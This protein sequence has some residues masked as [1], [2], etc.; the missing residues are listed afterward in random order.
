MLFV[1]CKEMPYHGN[2]L[3]DVGLAVAVIDA[4]PLQI[5]VLDERG[6]ITAANRAWKDF[7]DAN[8]AHHLANPVGIDY[9]DVCRH[10][11]GPAAEEAPAFA[12][13]LQSVLRGERASFE[14]DYPCHSPAVLRWF[15]ARV[16]PLRRRVAAAAP[17]EG[18]GPLIGAVV[19]HL[20][21]TDR[22][23]AEM[24]NA[25]LAA[26]DALTGLPNRRFLDVFAQLEL[27]RFRRFGN[28][29]A[30]LMIDLDMFKAVNDAYG[31]AAGDEVLRHVAAVGGA[32]F[33]GC[34]L[35][36]RLGG[37]EFTCL[38]PRL[39]IAEARLAAERFRTA[40][41][42]SPI[43]VASH[44]VTVTA[45]V[46]VTEASRA[47]HDMEDVLKRADAALYHAKT[48]GRNRVY[49]LSPDGALAL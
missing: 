1:G 23:R 40:L 11:A 6:I 5:C 39:D 19:A 36:A 30:V 28:P 31:H 9:L 35:F 15:T 33:R 47:D 37:D 17:T 2:L 45:S 3:R 34:D 16:T 25:R 41:E 32:C 12:K 21:I 26:T 10:A 29:L 46:G 24:D 20:N 18:P 4:L 14:I 43:R 7:A 49:A 38:M 48:E 22:K 8:G 42:A 27:S 44:A 13:G